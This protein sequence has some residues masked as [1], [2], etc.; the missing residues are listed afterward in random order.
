MIFVPILRDRVRL[1]QGVALVAA[2]V[3]L[4]GCVAPDVDDTTGT[5]LSQPAATPGTPPR[6]AVYADDI[7]IV[8]QEVSHGILDL[9]VVSGATVPPKVQFTDV[10][11]IITQSKGV[12]ADIDT[13]PYTTLLR[14]RILLLTRLKLRFVEHTLPP[15]ITKKGKKDS[16]G[17]TSFSADYEIRSEMRGRVKDEFYRIQVQFVDIHSGEVL[18]DGLYRIRKEGDSTTFGGSTMAPEDAGSPPPPLS[19][20]ANPPQNPNAPDPT[21]TPP[22]PS[23]GGSGGGGGIY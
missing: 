2:T 6:Q 21:Y 10:T 15:L 4:A 3:T 13:E 1:I 5:H 18:F 23:G 17:D 9:P 20:P 22:P 7:A 11:S 14:D 12:L 16:S 8:G 19:A